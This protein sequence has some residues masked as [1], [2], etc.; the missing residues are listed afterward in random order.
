MRVI[1]NAYYH[2]LKSKNSIVIETAKKLSKKK[3]IK[4][5]LKIEEKYMEV[6]ILKKTRTRRT[7]VK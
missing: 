1:K 4:L 6:I 2:W 5:F 3:G 7:Y